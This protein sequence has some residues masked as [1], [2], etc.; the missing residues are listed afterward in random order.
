MPRQGNWQIK[1]LYFT[2]EAAHSLGNYKLAAE[3]NYQ[4]GQD[5]TE[6]QKQ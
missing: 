5:S 2:L 6:I 4:Y 1:F 3:M